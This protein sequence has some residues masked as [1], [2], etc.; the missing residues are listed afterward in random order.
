M[1]EL[2]IGDH[3]WRQHVLDPVVGGERKAR[4]LVPRNYSTHPTGHYAREKAV[5]FPLIPRSEW[6]ER[7]KDQEA[8]KAR[9]SDIMLAAN[10]PCLDQNGRGYCWAHSGTGCVQAL[11]AIAGMPTVGLSAYAVACVI[12][13]FADEGGW[14]AEGMDFLVARGV[15]S[16]QFWPQRAVDRS[17]DNPKTWENGALHKVVE[18]WWDLSVAQYDRKF[19]F[20]VE[21][22]CYLLTDPV[23][24]DENWWSHSIMG[25][26]AVDGNARFGVSARDDSGKMLHW[27]DFKKV[28]GVDAVTGGFGVR[29]RNSWGPSYGDNGFFILT[30]DKAVSDGAVA[31]RTTL[32]NAA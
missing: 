16:E 21:I 24:K 3:N 18:G 5:D 12:K 15:P 19:S 29:P 14:G 6:P 17:L 10:V 28:W 22:T 32:V 7:I 23:V 13:N 26:D 1:S 27:E 8:N 2:I 31:P 4:G 20:D 25:C 30:G 9:V 11:R